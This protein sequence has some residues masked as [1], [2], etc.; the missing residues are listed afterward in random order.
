M[1]ATLYSKV[2]VGATWGP[3]TSMLD[4][5][6]RKHALYSDSQSAVERT[7]T[8]HTQAHHDPIS[9]LEDSRSEVLDIYRDTVRARQARG[10][11]TS[12]VTIGNFDGVHRGH[13][14]LLSLAGTLAG[15]EHR[16]IPMTFDPHPIRYFRPTSPAFELTTIEQRAQLLRAY[17]AHALFVLEFDELAANSSA[18]DFVST[19]LVDALGARHVIVGDGFRFA[20]KRSGTTDTLHELG[21]EYGFQ[22]HV[23]EHV[24]D[25][26]APVSSTRVREHLRAGEVAIANALLTRPYFIGGVVVHGDARGRQLGYPTANTKTSNQ[27]VIPDGIYTTTLRTEQF[28]A[29][30]ACTYVGKRPTYEADNTRNIE[31]FVLDYEGAAPLD[32]YDAQVTIDFHD[33]IRGDRAFRDSASLVEQMHVDV[34]AAR[35]W[36]QQ[37][38][39]S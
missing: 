35:A 19:F 30:P 12:V 27:V 24:M 5:H 21:Q 28:G 25:Q 13:Q 32:L 2:K 17:G 39:S 7:S 4:S 26:G 1:K 33:F 38:A 20:H 16:I 14:A 29:L 15:G 37:H 34:A 9:V 23:V 6:V 3:L 36:H 31:T 18:R 11:E 8:R 10:D 22:A